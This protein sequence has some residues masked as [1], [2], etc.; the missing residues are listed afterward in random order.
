MKIIP[1]E[2]I[3][4]I[5]KTVTAK[6][7]VIKFDDKKDENLKI[8]TENYGASHGSHRSHSSS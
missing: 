1:G 6:N 8:L 3:T 5:K 4:E 2:N 7:G